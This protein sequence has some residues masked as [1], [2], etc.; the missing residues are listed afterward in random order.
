[1]KTKFCVKHTDTAFLF[2]YTVKKQPIIA[3]VFLNILEIHYF[4]EK[5][6]GKLAL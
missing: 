2:E 6:K 1:M 3:C 4:L 5:T